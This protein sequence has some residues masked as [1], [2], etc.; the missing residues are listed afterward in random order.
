MAWTLGLGSPP[1]LEVV[2]E[3]ILKLELAVVS[4]PENLAE[5]E[6][7]LSFFWDSKHT[8]LTEL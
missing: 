1:I 4:L 6:L 2:V 3:L 5:S 7:C 8:G